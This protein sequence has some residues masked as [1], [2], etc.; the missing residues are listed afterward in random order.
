MKIKTI[1]LTRKRQKVIRKM[2][3]NRKR[4]DGTDPK[5]SSIGETYTSLS[6]HYLLH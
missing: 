5:Q 1:P 6:S 3:E 2:K 4:K